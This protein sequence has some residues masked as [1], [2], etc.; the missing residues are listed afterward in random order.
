MFFI[1]DFEVVFKPYNGR[2][3]IKFSIN[4]MWYH[5]GLML[6]F[7]VV[8]IILLKNNSLKLLFRLGVY[9]FTIWATKSASQQTLLPT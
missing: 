6:I 9:L 8:G 1:L 3:T 7:F 2:K 5:K 4:I